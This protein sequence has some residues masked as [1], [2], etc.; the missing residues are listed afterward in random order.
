MS[1][2]SLHRNVKHLSGQHVGGSD[3]AGN[4]GSSGSVNSGIRPLG[5]A[6]SKFH[7]AVPAG[8]M[9][10]AGSLGGDQALV[11]YNIQDSRFHKLGLHNRRD[12][13]DKGLPG[14]DH[15]SLR[16]GINI[17]CKLKVAQIVKKILR[18]QACASEVVH[19]LLF[20]VEIF[21]IFDHLLQS[22]TD[23]KSVSVGII[24]V[25]GVKDDHLVGILLVKIALHHGK[26]VQVCQ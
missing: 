3:A 14:K 16:D 2:S 12:Y 23:G 4:H 6:Q 5:A 22:R 17:P 21:Y 19:I 13:L 7:D 8:C 24:S 15:G 20:K 1:V 26:L 18:E 11:V 10:D 25:E 9:D